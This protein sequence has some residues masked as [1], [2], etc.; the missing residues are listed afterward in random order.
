MLGLF[1]I[2]LCT[3]H[4]FWPATFRLDPWVKLAYASI[5][6]HCFFLAEARSVGFAAVG[7]IA[8][9]YMAVTIN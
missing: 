3:L 7:L 5:G 8:N 9:C 4:S 2:L 6:K 1:T